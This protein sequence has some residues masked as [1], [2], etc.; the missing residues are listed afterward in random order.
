M[1]ILEVV[2][3][4]MAVP[5]VVHLLDIED[6]GVGESVELA[7]LQ[8]LVVLDTVAILIRDVTRSLGKRN[9]LL[10]L[11]K[12][13]RVMVLDDFGG[14]MLRHRMVLFQ[15]MARELAI[16]SVVHLFSSSVDGR[17]VEPIKLVVLQVLVVLDAIAILIGDVTRKLS[18]GDRL[19]LLRLGL[20]GKS[21]SVMV[22][23]Q[24]SVVPL[25][26]GM[27]LLEVMAWKLTVPSV[28]HLLGMSKDGRLVE[29]IDLM[30][31]QVL[32]VLD[33]VTILIGDV[34]LLR[35]GLD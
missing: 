4:K 1:V 3:W 28:V 16:P 27:V 10:F 12:S 8:V 7:M 29:L 20:L 14:V 31:L 19:L 13:G 30:V 6:V 5:S 23:E 32:V 2:A 21:G 18:L 9:R 34:S 15:V 11:G 25:R 26:H 24:V 35:S 33:A 22:L 17:L